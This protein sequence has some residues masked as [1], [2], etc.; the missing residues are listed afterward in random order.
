MAASSALSELQLAS[1]GSLFP[2]TPFACL[3]TSYQ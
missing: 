3:P 1:A 2:L